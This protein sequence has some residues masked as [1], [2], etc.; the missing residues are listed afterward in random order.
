MDYKAL[1]IVS[2]GNK[3][4]DF[5]VTVDMAKHLIMQMKTD[6]AHKYRDYLIKLEKAWNSP[7]MVI[8][9]ALQMANTKVLDYQQEITMLSEKVTELKP[10]ADFYEAVTGS[11]D[12]IDLGQVAKVLNVK[13]YGRNNLF[14]FLRNKD[15][16]MDNNQPYQKFIDRGYFRLV[17]SKFTKPCGSTHINI[18]TV[19][20]QKG[21][22]YIRK[23]VVKES[24]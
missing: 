8:A 4:F 3:T 20:Y 18:K 19:V 22:D 12:T 5:I 23:Q 17:E 15:I 1:D 10:K 24:N 14:E 6:K 13:G 2:N 21:V 9:R 7:D 16:L 11:T